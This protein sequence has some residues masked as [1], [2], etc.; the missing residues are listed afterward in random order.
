MDDAHFLATIRAEPRDMS[1]RHVYADWLDDRGDVRG[2]YVRLQIERSGLSLDD[3][4]DGRLVPLCDRMMELRGEID[5]RWLAEMEQPSVIIGNPTPFGTKWIGTN[6]YGI[7]QF[8]GSFRSDP[9]EVQPDLGL[10]QCASLEARRGSPEI[11]W[12]RQDAQ[13]L[14]DERPFAVMR[15][16]FEEIDRA[17]G[18]AGIEPPEPLIRLVGD[19]ELYASTQVDYRCP[20]ELQDQPTPCPLLP[21]VRILPFLYDSQFCYFGMLYLHPSG[22][23]CAVV[24][25]D[26]R[27]LG[28]HPG[29]DWGRLE[30]NL[31][32]TSPSFA[33]FV[34]R[35]RLDHSLWNYA[36]WLRLRDVP[37][38]LHSPRPERPELTPEE[39]AYADHLAR[40]NATR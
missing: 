29:E 22:G 5:D 4:P 15:E 18:A 20:V 30:A 12:Y 24:S 17:L 27:F 3:D 11:G 13:S 31:S 8:D 16:R 28:E 1:R 32:F 19:E 21:H 25:D 37:P 10:E 7:R 36:D 9:Y 26:R 34:H 14:G 40:T 33:T 35:W 38:S 6:L 23:H 2:E 39:Q